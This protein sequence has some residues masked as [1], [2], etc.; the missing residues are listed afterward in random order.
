[1]TVLGCV[2]KYPHDGTE[3]FREEEEEEY[4]EEEE[5][6]GESYGESWS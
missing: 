6:E 3:V 4:E 5:G 1:M 2:R